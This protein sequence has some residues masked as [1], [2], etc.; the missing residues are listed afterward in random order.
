MEINNINKLIPYIICLV[1]A[2]I[3]FFA[4][5]MFNQNKILGLEDTKSSTDENII[6]TSISSEGLSAWMVGKIISI[7]EK[8]I[9]IQDMTNNKNISLAF[10]ENTIVT[11]RIVEENGS[12]QRKGTLSDLKVGEIMN[13]LLEDSYAKEIVLTIGQSDQTHQDGANIPNL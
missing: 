1:I 11:L 13:F 5:Y 10:D 7:E 3:F 6:K 2:L 12:S 4:G 9:L 8:E